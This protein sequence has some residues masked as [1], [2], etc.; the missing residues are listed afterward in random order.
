M[1]APA[2]AF[3]GFAIGVIVGNDLRSLSAHLGAGERQNALDQGNAAREVAARVEEAREIVRRHDR[4]KIAGLEP[5]HRANQIEADR[6][7]GRGIPDEAGTVPG[8]K[9]RDDQRARRYHG[10]DN[11]AA[12]HGWTLR[13]F[14]Q[15]RCWAGA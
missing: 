6:R 7:A 15:A 10:S 3:A 1:A 2:V 5:S 4:D 14:S 12:A 9:R 8:Q 13:R 11:G